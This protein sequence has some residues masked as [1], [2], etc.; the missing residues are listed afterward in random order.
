MIRHLLGSGVDST[1]AAVEVPVVVPEEVVLRTV[2]AWV[3][4]SAWSCQIGFVLGETTQAC[5]LSKASLLVV[6]SAV[7]ERQWFGFYSVSDC[8]TFSSCRGYLRFV[9]VAF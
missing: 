3:S 2:S 9:P 6:Q 5:D 8:R 1:G 7:L 4:G